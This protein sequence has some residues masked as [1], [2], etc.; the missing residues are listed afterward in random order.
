MM[1]NR[2]VILGF[3]LTAI[4]L[5]SCAP[6]GSEIRE[7][8]A[9]RLICLNAGK[10]D[11]MLLMYQDEAYLI[12]T[13]Y[14]QTWPAL[15]AMLRQYGVD[16]LNGVFLTH[17]HEDHMGGLAKLAQSGIG[18]DAWY[19]AGIYSGAESDHPAVL[20]AGERN[21]SVTWLEA[22]NTIPVGGDGAFFVLGPL[23]LDA[24]N[25]NNNSLV[26]RFSSPQGSI[27]FAG[28]M[29]EDEENELLLSGAFSSC[30]V[31][32]AGHH[33]DNKATTL[34]MLKIVQPK[35]AVILTDTREEPDT[36]AVSTLQ[37]L[38]A[39]GCAAYIS[40]DF[41]DALMVTLKN[42]QQP[43]VTD[44]VW[45]GAPRRAENVSLAIDASQD[46]LTIIN[47]S[48]E[49]LNLAG[50][51]VY[52]TKGNE[53]FALPDAAVAPGGQ[54]VTGTESTGVGVDWQFSVKRLW[55]K[56]KL[57]RAILYDAYGRVLA[58]TDNGLE[59]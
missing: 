29:K 16:R 47:R 42:N 40:Q 53:L 21:E 20:A 23:T 54:F 52:S 13:G 6:A 35:I 10:A 57:D 14:E 7:D 25:E 44:V 15:E 49:S 48:G 58:C 12:D 30:D 4:L 9:L 56:K 43:A 33:G 17:C 41:H 2:A 39:V 50:C 11:C 46:T 51:S 26:M 18:V 19:A 1:K 24:G 55:H 32:K 22:G 5:S 34:K 59:E 36:P 38:N 8:G 37:R 45:E 31:L 28:D 27:L 3:L